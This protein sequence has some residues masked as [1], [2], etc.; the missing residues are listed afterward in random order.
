MQSVANQ[1][2]LAL[3]NNQIT[4]EIDGKSIKKSAKEAKLLG[5]VI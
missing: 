1:R 5:L 4:I 3:S 2:L